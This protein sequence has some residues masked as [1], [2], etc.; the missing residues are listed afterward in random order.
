[1]LQYIE[2]VDSL[3]CLI[4][5]CSS[6]HW[7]VYLAALENIIKYYF[8]H[9]LLNYAHLMPVHLVQMNALENDYPVT[10]HSKVH[11]MSTTNFQ[12]EYLSEQERMP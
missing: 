12:V 9:D 8:A 1:M 6:G 3:L 10:V 7:E 2:Q 5:A 4:G 11:G